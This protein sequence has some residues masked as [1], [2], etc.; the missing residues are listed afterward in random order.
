L[1][2]VL[3]GGLYALS[4]LIFIGIFVLAGYQKKLFLMLIKDE[5]APIPRSSSART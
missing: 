2:K 3:M 4:C 5:N 1:K